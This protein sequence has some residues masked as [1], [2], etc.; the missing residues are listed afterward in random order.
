MDRVEDAGGDPDRVDELDGPL[1]RE[2]CR[3][4]GLQHDG[5]A[6][7]ERRTDLIGHER[8]R[9][10]PRRD[11][12]DDADR[13]A[14]CEA[15]LVL[16]LERHVVAAQLVGETGEELEVLC[17]ARRLDDGMSERF[18]LLLGQQPRDLGHGGPDLERGLVHECG[19][20]R[21]RERGPGR[22]SLRGGLDRGVDV[23]V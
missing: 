13:S 11:R 6:D 10:V 14:E 4:C 23:T 12:R 2:R 1:R 22:E 7:R 3:R 21:R 18:A 8:E 19:A 16:V 15:E 17:D 20:L 5:A 9:E